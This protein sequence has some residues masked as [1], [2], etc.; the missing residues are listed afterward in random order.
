MTKY[1][2]SFPT[3]FDNLMEEF[4]ILLNDKRIKIFSFAI[5]LDALFGRL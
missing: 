3:A 5:N 4:V 1:L 2:L